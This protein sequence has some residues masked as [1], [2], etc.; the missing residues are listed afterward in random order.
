M[1]N[2]IKSVITDYTDQGLIVNYLDQLENAIKKTDIE[3]IKYCLYEIS[4]WYN[5]N[6][7]QIHSNNFVYNHHEHDLNKQKIE[8]F[9]KAFETYQLDPT[10]N[11][12]DNICGEG[13]NMTKSQ[14]I[15]GYIQK[16]NS[17]LE[18]NHEEMIVDLCL[19]ITKVF[20][21]IIPDIEDGIWFKNES[22]KQDANIIKGKLKLAL[23]DE[24][25]NA[26]NDISTTTNKPIIFLSHQS[27]DKQYGD[28]IEEL[29]TRLGVKK[30]QL[31][32]TSHP[33]HKV[34]LGNN[35]YDYLREHIHADIL[36]IV[37]WSDNYLESPACLNE[38]GAA[39]VTQ[40]E[41]VQMYIPPF[42]FHNP[43]VGKC[44]ISTREA[45]IMLNGDEQCKA[46][47]VEL[48]SRVEKK[49]SISIDESTTSFCIDQ[50]INTIK[51]LNH[52]Q[53]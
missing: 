14:F 22:A 3:S 50:F 16:L 49:L 6:I 23:I 36:M 28:A 25:Q 30:E 21:G 27:S 20:S 10:E 38:M 45:G 53:T 52:G 8:M 35:I 17:T 34:P 46:G 40:P 33:L 12:Y 13:T 5:D 41:V 1:Y 43:K 37:L 31:I 4:K 11:Y 48:K 29:L 19:E 26:D 7:G 47:M 15:Q 2:G 44:A 39:W 32:Y 42:D 24:K 51:E 18:T 9:V